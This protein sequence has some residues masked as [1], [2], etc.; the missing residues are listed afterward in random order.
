MAEIDPF[1]EVDSRLNKASL[2]AITYGDFMT[3]LMIFFLLMFAFSLD[4][5]VRKESKF[6]ESLANIQKEFGGRISSER[7]DKLTVKKRE[8]TAAGQLEQIIQRKNLHGL[9]QVE[10]S[11]ENVNLILKAPVL[12]D[13]G[14]ARL[15]EEAREILLAVAQTL[16]SMPG[17]IQ[18][19]GHTDDVPVARNLSY[20]SNW[21]LSMARAYEVVKFFSSEGGIYPGRLA[22]TGYGEYRPRV[23]NAT[24]EN[25]A[26]NR[27]IEISLVRGK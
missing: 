3:Y 25:R 4:A 8:E 16:R 1:E 13:S 19:G 23:V 15:K 20:A 12:F 6:E 9:A 17:E 27:R 10:V 24:P 26:L 22:A 14:D 2:W 7:L 18:V 21:Q 11:E 5:K